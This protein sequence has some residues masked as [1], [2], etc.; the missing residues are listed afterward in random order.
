MH[1]SNCLDNHIGLYLSF[2]L[3]CPVEITSLQSRPTELALVG[4]QL[5]SLGFKH[6]TVISHHLSLLLPADLD[7]IG[8]KFF[9]CCFQRRSRFS[10]LGPGRL[11]RCWRH[12]NDLF[13]YCGFMEKFNSLGVCVRWITVM[14][15]WRHSMGLVD[16]FVSFDR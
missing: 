10:N 13:Y 2:D 14:Q 9:T 4:E 7:T 16:L 3:S 12:S 15:F 6:P 5:L 8:E 11:W 1:S